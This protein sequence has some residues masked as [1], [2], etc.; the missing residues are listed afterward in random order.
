MSAQHIIHD[1]NI[2]GHRWVRTVTNQRRNYSTQ[3]S[4]KHT[5]TVNKKQPHDNHQCYCYRE[6]PNDGVQHP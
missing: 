4:V 6:V 5:C 1:P 3:D 2:C